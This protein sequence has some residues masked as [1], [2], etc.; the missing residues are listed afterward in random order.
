MHK[1]TV[2]FERLWR[3]TDDA[4]KYYRSASKHIPSDIHVPLLDINPEGELEKEIKDIVEELGIMMNVNKEQKEVLK[5]FINNVAHIL[6]HN[7]QFQSRWDQK[8][9][10]PA[11]ATPYPSPRNES[12]NPVD[13]TTK[14]KSPGQDDA[15]KETYKWFKVNADELF[16]RVEDRIEQLEEVKRSAEST[17]SSVGAIRINQI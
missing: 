1:Q 12:P 16:T 11:D 10:R 2:G 13:T 6:D 17:A 15:N 4:R 5:Q 8:P 7:D 14:S 3:W 9:C